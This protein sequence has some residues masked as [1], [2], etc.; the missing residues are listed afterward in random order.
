[1]GHSVQLVFKRIEIA[2]IVLERDYWNGVPSVISAS[3]ADAADI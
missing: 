2:R 1:M 3:R